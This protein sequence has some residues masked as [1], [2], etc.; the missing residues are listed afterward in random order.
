MIGFQVYSVQFGRNQIVE[1]IN[2]QLGLL[3]MVQWMQFG[4]KT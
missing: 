1:I 2:I 4:L 3:V